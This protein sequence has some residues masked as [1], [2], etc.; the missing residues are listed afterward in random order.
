MKCSNSML[1]IDRNSGTCYEIGSHG[2]CGINMIFYAELDN[3][4]YGVC[5]CAHA[6]EARTLIYYEPHDQCYFVFQ[7]ASLSKYYAVS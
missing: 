1:R 2:P 3:E 5:D 6:H 7:Q 4:E